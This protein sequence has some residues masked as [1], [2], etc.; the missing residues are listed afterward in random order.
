LRPGL[1]S[2]PHR[3][4]GSGRF[5][6]IRSKPA[7]SAAQAG[8][9]A[10]RQTIS[11]SCRPANKAP[12]SDHNDQLSWNPA[13]ASVSKMPDDVKALEAG[14]SQGYETRSRVCWHG[15]SRSRERFS[16]A[17]APRSELCC[18]RALRVSGTP[19][20]LLVDSEAGSSPE[21]RLEHPRVEFIAK[22]LLCGALG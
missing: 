3:P 5:V 8:I 7:S 1:I 12:Q 11:A 14:E 15:R 9:S 17:R 19:F 13:A 4:H 16:I 21:S 20:A 18:R 2:P 6:P 22:I 10:S